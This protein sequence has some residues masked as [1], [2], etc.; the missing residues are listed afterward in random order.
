MIDFDDI[1]DWEPDL[2]AA[3][4]SH[5]PDSIGETLAA[6]A[7]EYVED[8]RDLLFDLASRDSVIDATLTWI[9]SR[10]IVGYHGSRLTDD[11]IAS[12]RVSELL[13]LKAEAR[14]HRLTRALSRHPDWLKV[15]DQ[16]DA[17]IEA[18]GQ[19]AALGVREN[20]VHLTLSKAGLTKG[21]N[22]Y[23]TY[24]AEFDQHVAYGLFGPAGKE[25]LADDGKPTLIRVAVPGLLAL[26]G[27]HPCFDIENVRVG[28]GIPNLVN[29]F[30]KAWSYRL[31]HPG[32]Q[33]RTLE[34]DCGMTFSSTVP[35]HW[36]V[37]LDTLLSDSFIPIRSMRKGQ[38][39]G[40]IASTPSNVV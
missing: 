7:P 39:D 14:R 35:A 29:E 40:F 2:A 10:D 21:F 20:Q 16:L 12:V 15:A 38:E 11:D 19:G 4:S 33:S 34:I 26:E 17:T 28:G 27:A 24:G 1:D 18:Y 30:L 9:R 32:F 23:L 13:P 8:A 3:L 22:H 5:L 25:I 37:G 6:A 36:I 31:A